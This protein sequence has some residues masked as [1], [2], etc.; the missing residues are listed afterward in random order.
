VYA[1][2]RRLRPELPVPINNRRLTTAELSSARL[3]FGGQANCTLGELSEIYPGGEHADGIFTQR[4]GSASCVSSRP[5]RVRIACGRTERCPTE[6]RANGTFLFKSFR[7]DATGSTVTIK[8]QRIQVVSC[9]GFVEV[10]VVAPGGVQKAS[11]GGSAGSS[12]VITIVV[13]SRTVEKPWG[14]MIE[15]YAKVES[16]VRDPSP[17]ECESSAVR[18]EEEV[19]KP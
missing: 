16:V 2:K 7:P 17:E 18:E 13:T 1:A 15:E 4:R 10:R 6:L 19:V 11:G 3:A 8:R 9:E 12:V 14:V 5:S